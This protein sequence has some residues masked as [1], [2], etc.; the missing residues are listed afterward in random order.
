MLI[1]LV[2]AFLGISLLLYCLFAGADF[3]GGM[4]ESFLGEK[5][6]ED[7]KRIIGNAIAPV[8][9]AN[10]V[11]II[12]AIVI[13]F[14]G[15]PNAYSEISILFHIPILI[16]LVGIILRGC[17]FTFRHYDAIRGRSQVYYSAIFIFSSYLAPL[18]L[19]I[20][21][22]AL[23]LGRIPLNPTSF[24]DIYIFP[25]FN[26]FSLAVGVFTCALFSF[27]AAVYLVGETNDV[28]LKTIFSKKARIGNLVAV[29][30][31]GLVFL[32][33]EGLGLSLVQ[34][35]LKNGITMACLA[36]ATMALF[37]LWI[38]LKKKQ[39]WTSRMLASSQVAF[40]LV[41][42]FAAQF[43]VIMTR[44]NSSLTIYNSAAPEPTLRY[45]LLALISGVLLIFPALFYLLRVFKKSALS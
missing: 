27:L 21:A 28:E 37:P 42:W 6:T 45:L 35:F 24:S 31:G 22:G 16:M 34:I 26:W 14:N 13:L 5:R 38:S 19:G 4:L 3:G 43:P 8:W 32:S 2:V 36:A 23:F 15:F 12:L 1:N 29:I 40:I 20:I 18:M 44:G 9:E 11:W 7:Q 39:I 10:H 25:W 41:G 30:S 33:A 17:A